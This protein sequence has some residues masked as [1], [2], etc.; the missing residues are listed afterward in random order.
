MS[1][2]RSP[3][4]LVALVVAL[5]AAGLSGCVQPDRAVVA[6][7]LASTQADRWESIDEP[8][9]RA[10]VEAACNGCEY[11]TYNADQDA[12]RQAQQFDAAL[13]EGADVIVLNPVDSVL[14]AGLAGRAGEVPVIA[15]DRFVMGADW[16]VSVDAARTGR[17]LAQSV[18]DGVGPGARVLLVNGAQTD[19]NGRT[20][21]EAVRSVFKRQDIKVLAELDPS[22]WSAEEAEQ[23][24]L[25]HEDLL[26][27]VDAIVASNDTEASGVASALAQLDLDEA[28]YPFITGQ[29]AELDALQRIVAGEQAM[30]VYKPLP[31]LAERAADLAI[32]VLTGADVVGAVD[33][34]G[35]PSFFLEPRSVTSETLATTV[36][37][38]RVYTLEELC[39]SLLV[40]R[41]QEL[42]LL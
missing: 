7:L 18:V 31:A 20:I 38:D 16:F 42:G 22:S 17:L 9:F 24:V 28:D 5:L 4:L 14:A 39:P 36:V 23:F 1:P 25:D 35:V 13:A 3:R 21:K 6:F 30:T 2:A 34:E 10:R 12:E 26:A 15:Y 37:H 8:G 41:C 29:D 32:D 11:V 33:H 19:A 40:E 27:D